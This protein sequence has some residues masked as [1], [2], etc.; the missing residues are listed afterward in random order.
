RW[1]NVSGEIFNGDKLRIATI[2]RVETQKGHKYLLHALARLKNINWSWDIFGDGSLAM[3]Y[4]NEAQKLG[5]ADR[6]V[7]HGVVPD[8]EN[9]LTNI[10]LVI[11]PS[12]W[13]GLS[14]VV[15]EVMGAGRCIIVTGPAGDELVDAGKTGLTVPARDVH[16]LAE[17]IKFLYVTPAVARERAVN[18]REYA[19]T[20]FSIEKN[21]IALRN[22]YLALK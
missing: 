7:W 19:R 1:L 9:Y 14:L 11:A 15:M 13:E 12:L 5:I 6:I 4:K 22:L 17:A 10:D 18:A 2:G 20:H 21:L 8:V 3:S 16:A